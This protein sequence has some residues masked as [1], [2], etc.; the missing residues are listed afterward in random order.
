MAKFKPTWYPVDS[1]NISDVCYDPKSKTLYIK[2]LSGK[3][4]SYAGVSQSTFDQLNAA[5]SIGAFFS[6]EIKP[7]YKYK[8]YIGS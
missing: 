7:N 1:S 2:F 4:Y 6:K 3:A 8:E 5:P